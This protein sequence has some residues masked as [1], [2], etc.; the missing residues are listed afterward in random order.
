MAAK[1]MTIK[2]YNELSDELMLSCECGW[3]GKSTEAYGEMYEEILDFECPKC[4]EM[5]LIVNLN[6]GCQEFWDP[7]NENK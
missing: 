6:K 5:L 1:H 4:D 2:T 3:E 7:Q